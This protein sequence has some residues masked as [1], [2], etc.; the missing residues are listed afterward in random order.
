MV[1]RNSPV[2]SLD[3]TRITFTISTLECGGAERVLV[4]I[5]ETLHQRGYQ[6]S[7]ITL[8]GRD[9]DF[10]SL[11]PGISRVALDLAKITRS[12]FHAL[13]NN[14]RRILTL[15]QVINASNPDIIISF[16]NRMNMLVL[17]AIQGM[18]LPVI[19][20]EAVDPA[21]ADIGF[22]LRRLQR[23][24]Y[25]LAA[26]LSSPSTGVD[27]CFD[28]VPASKRVVIHN[29]I[30]KSARTAQSAPK[31][32]FRHSERRHVAAMGRLA[33]EKGFDLLLEAF[34]RIAQ[35]N[36]NWDLIIMGEGEK[37]VELE[38]QMRE[39]GLEERA[40]LL[41][42][43]SDPF[44]VLRAAD[45]FV[46]S[47]RS[48][49]FGNVL[50]EAMACDLP[51]ISFDCPSGPR[52]IIRDGMNG[53]LVPPENVGALAAAIDRLMNNDAERQ[54][55]VASARESIYRFDVETIAD[56]WERLILTTLREHG[57]SR[58]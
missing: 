6:V 2:N 4:N 51:V 50:V 5:S 56:Q 36:P 12:P 48:E 22:W 24:T 7:V 15:R 26:C 58:K 40:T 57:D 30:T 1:R 21:S 55:L 34:S 9:H 23:W 52:D 54:R 32:I 8:Y 33:S 42:R 41:G 18:D 27:R 25:P 10:Y 39:L 29:P 20:V 17:L 28:W 49:A 46:L 44:P 19:I 43:V 3:V 45:L 31:S 35:Q 16:Q 37:R 38:T 53:A 14:I 13:Y 11:S 47:S